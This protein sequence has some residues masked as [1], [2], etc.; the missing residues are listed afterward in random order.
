MDE[1]VQ[2]VITVCLEYISGQLL[3]SLS[4]ILW[5]DMM[6]GV[7]IWFDFI[8]LTIIQAQGIFLHCKSNTVESLLTFH[9]V[10]WNIIKPGGLGSLHWFGQL[11][12]TAYAVYICWKKKE[13]TND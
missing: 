12:T 10:N 2:R 9:S 6:I 3:F 8:L 5:L 7:K 1:W 11:G 4:L 13:L